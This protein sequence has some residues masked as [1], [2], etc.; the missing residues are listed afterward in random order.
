MQKK[1]RWGIMGAGAV[2]HRWIKGAAQLEDLEIKAISSRSIASAKEVARRWN[3]PCVM[4]YDE[5]VNCPDI[6]II[7]IAVPHT[8]H[9]ELA[10]KAMNAGENVLLEK[11]AT[12]NAE[13]FQELIECAKLNNVF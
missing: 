12:V 9:R 8:V 2:I 7:Y 13:E 11:P 3:I 10:L 4:T 5:M 6:D 1:I